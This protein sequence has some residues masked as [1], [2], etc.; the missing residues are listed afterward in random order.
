MKRWI[1]ALAALLMI[2]CTAW[3]AEATAEAVSGGQSIDVNGNR[4]DR[5]NYYE[6]TPWHCRH[7]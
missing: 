4:V 6:I 3:A 5:K 7:G 2:W 1:A